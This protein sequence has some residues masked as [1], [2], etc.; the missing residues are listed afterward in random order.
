MNSGVSVLI[1]TRQRPKR[2]EL[3]IESIKKTAKGPFEVLTWVDDDDESYSSWT[4]KGSRA[5][6]RSRMLKA[7]IEKAQYPYL[8]NA[9]DDV[10]YE[11]EGWDE[12]MAKAIPDDRIAVVFGVDG[13]KNVPG[14]LFFHRRF[15][16]LTG[17][18]PDD[19]EHFGI[20]TYVAD[21]MRQIERLIQVQV[22]CR[23]MHF[24]NNKAES[25][26]TYTHTRTSGM[27]DRDRERLERHRKGYMKQDIQTLK[28]E[29]ER[30]RNA[31]ETGEPD[32]AGS[33]N[34]QA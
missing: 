24:R 25:D 2:L 26:E 33:R 20:D 10:I 27:S 7:L 16:E 4:I 22:M 19:F 21:V 5:T 12:I 17:C 11:T 34:Q 9:S 1:P 30:F 13:W 32:T 3:T 23:H 29:I 15:Y 6:T 28:A 8:M 31:V 18:F 14:H